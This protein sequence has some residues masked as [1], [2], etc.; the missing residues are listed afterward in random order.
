MFGNPAYKTQFCYKPVTD[1]FK[2]SKVWRPTK[3][4]IA[5]IGDRDWT[6]KF[7]QALQG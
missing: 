4:I 2:L 3:H 7:L 5:H 1:K 6:H